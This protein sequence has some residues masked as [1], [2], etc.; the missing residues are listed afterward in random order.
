MHVPG[1]GT[2]IPTETDYLVG[3][4]PNAHLPAGAGEGRRDPSGLPEPKESLAGTGA[5]LG[6]DLE[7]RGDLNGQV[8]PR[9]VDPY[10]GRSVEHRFRLATGDPTEE[11]DERRGHRRSAHARLPEPVPLAGVDL[12]RTADR[13]ALLGTFGRRPERTRSGTAKYPARVL[14]L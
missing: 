4:V 9:A 12:L 1:Q 5:F 6:C 11:P 13:S 7:E 14:S 3:S 10:E 8:A 2:D